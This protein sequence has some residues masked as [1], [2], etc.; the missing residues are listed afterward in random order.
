M[1]NPNADY[2]DGDDMA[3]AHTARQ[4]AQLQGHGRE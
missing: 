4:I 3:N 1:S 2:L